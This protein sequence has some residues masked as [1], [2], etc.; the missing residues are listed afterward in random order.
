MLRSRIA[1]LALTSAAVLAPGATARANDEV[2]PRA[3][4][5][6]GTWLTDTLSSAPAGELTLSRQI[7][8]LAADG[9][10]DELAAI[11]RTL[12]RSHAQ[13][14]ESG[15]SQ[16]IFTEAAANAGRADE[17]YEISKA[18]KYWTDPVS[19]REA[20]DAT[21]KAI[22]YD[23]HDW[24]H[25]ARAGRIFSTRHGDAA[26]E[27]HAAVVCAKV[28]V[29]LRPREAYAHEGVV[30]GYLQSGQAR[31]ALETATRV[32]E[33]AKHEESHFS[34][35]RGDLG[36]GLFLSYKGQAALA[37]G[38]LRMARESLRLAVTLNAK[39]AHAGKLL[40]GLLERYRSGATVITLGDAE[41]IGINRETD[42][43]D[44][45]VRVTGVHA[46]S[47]AEA[48]GLQ[49]DDVI[50]LVDGLPANDGTPNRLVSVRD[51]VRAGELESALFE[52][53]R[54]DELVYFVL[55]K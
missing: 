49:V 21:L 1:V 3:A 27:P 24:R 9:P 32:L 30:R 31:R 41:L 34:N 51:A 50:T 17:Y 14:I 43:D 28:A 2:A 35:W 36:R 7:L 11:E 40:A 45:A 37:L 16:R 12:N 20:L 33:I 13:A 29:S 44:D 39:D 19:C 47:P 23:P 6:A 26:T 55:K 4:S 18:I 52:V 53:R 22:Y 15:K 8:K 10:L 48:A 5:R 42:T 54:G 38:D 25:W 46:D